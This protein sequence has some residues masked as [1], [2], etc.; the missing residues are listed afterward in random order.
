MLDALSMEKR[1]KVLQ[2]V[3]LE[4]LTP[5]DHAE[6]NSKIRAATALVRNGAVRGDVVFMDGSCPAAA[7]DAVLLG[8]L[9]DLAPLLK[10][11]GSFYSGSAADCVLN[12][13]AREW[14]L[15]HLAT[16]VAV[17]SLTT[18]ES[19]IAVVKELLTLGAN[20]AREDAYGQ[21]PL[22]FAARAGRL[23]LVQLLLD[24]APHEVN[25]LDFQ[26]WTPLMCAAMAG[27]EE[28]AKMLL[29]KGA[30][31]ELQDRDGLS[32]RDWALETDHEDI[33]DVLMVAPRGVR[34][35][36][37]KVV[38]RGSFPRHELCIA[39]LILFTV[40]WLRV[41]ARGSGVCARSRWRCKGA[42]V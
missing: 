18:A 33:L 11:S 6:A 38:S 22:F 23:D 5:L 37:G 40:M 13:D 25:H 19:A 28:V 30:D 3:D 36:S 12:L 27:R 4:G 16:T 7:V 10:A 20:P 42:G 26:Q 14:S 32:A 21:T 9:G 39:F 35:R 24:S 1:S 29:A 8:R 34:G 31:A 17:L 2:A 41:V 15:L